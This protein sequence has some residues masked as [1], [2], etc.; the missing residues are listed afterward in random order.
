M[1]PPTTLF[2][3]EKTQKKKKKTQKKRKR[4]KK[5]E[6]PKVLKWSEKG[7][8]FLFPSL[9]LLERAKSLMS[10]QIS[11]LPK[12]SINFK[13]VKNLDIFSGCP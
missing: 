7:S 5:A 12:G 10:A 11:F 2:P 8:L 13:A 3:L 4:T 6:H 1:H 9:F